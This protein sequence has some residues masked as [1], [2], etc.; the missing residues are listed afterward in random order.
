M[1][2]REPQQAPVPPSSPPKKS[3]I[4]SLAVIAVIVGVLL[5]GVFA[6]SAMLP[7]PAPAPAPEHEEGYDVI[8]SFD[9]VVVHTE[10]GTMLNVMKDGRYYDPDSKEFI[11]SE[12]SDRA[13]VTLMVKWGDK[14]MTGTDV[15]TGTLD[16]D[17]STSMS[18]DDIFASGSALHVDSGTRS[19]QLTFFMV[20]SF[21]GNTGSVIDM[22]TDD[23]MGVTGINCNVT[24]DPDADPLVIEMHGDVDP[25]VVSG[26]I[27][28]SVVP[29]EAPTA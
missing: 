5:V 12:P 24:M 27:T 26:K 17:G 22:N 28:V 16:A 15:A 9:D 7:S 3:G 20:S 1:P 18:L 19:I 10:N 4:P 6:L 8:I 11:L 29:T 13:Q 14:T 23:G 25:Y 21:E 2:P